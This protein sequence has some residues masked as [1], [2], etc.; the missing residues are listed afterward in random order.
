MFY[1][2]SISC[3]EIFFSMRFII[4]YCMSKKKKYGI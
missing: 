3:L 2:G 4:M 1:Y